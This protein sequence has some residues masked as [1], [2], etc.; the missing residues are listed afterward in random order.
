MQRLIEQAAK[1]SATEVYLEVREDKP[2]PQKLY[3][4]LGFQRIDRRENYY[5]PD[6]VAAIVMRLDVSPDTNSQPV[7][8][9]IETSCDETGIGIVRGTTL[10]ANVI[11]SS[12]DQHA[13]FGGVVPEL[14]LEH[15]SRH[16]NRLCKRLC[17]MQEFQ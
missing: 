12:M 5:Q 3:E 2:A 1:L 4:Q 6:G 8:L 11:S 9:G 15:I 13:R 14:Q 16:L 10:L 7:V 17:T